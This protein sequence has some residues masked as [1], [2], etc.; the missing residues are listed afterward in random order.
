MDDGRAEA[1]DL[2]S[3]L[4]WVKRHMPLTEEEIRLLPDLH[5]VRLA[6]S[7]HLEPKVAA[8]LEG[9]LDRGAALFLTTCNAA[10]VRDEVVH[11]MEARGAAAHAW[12]GM[13]AAD[14]AEAERRALA[15]K[16]THLWETGANLTAAL[17]ASGGGGAGVAAGM[18][19]T[20]SGITR[21][22]ALSTN[23]TF[24]GFPIYNCDEVPIKE[25][26]HNRYL[27]GQTAWHTFTERTRLSLQRKRV[28]VVGYG[29]VGRGVA[30]VA[31]S[32]GGTVSVAERD[33]TRVLEAR[34]DGFPAG[35]LEELARSADILVT[36]TGAHHVVTSKHFAELADG[37]F[38]MNVGHTDDE[39]DVQALGPRREILP[40]VEEALVGRRTIFLIAGGSMANL[41]AGQGDTL[42]SF[43]I[44][45]AVMLAGVRFTLS[46]EA[47]ALPPGLHPLP[48]SAWEGVARRAASG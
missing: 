47:R 5:G 39:I 10:T 30:E 48:R 44:T 27:V 32:L 7:V 19:S 42:N 18:E 22:R 15:W 36:A 17:A 33:P 13:G 37:C 45:M 46:E 40:F 8:S 12:R 25:R 35:P 43:D 41:V 26:L 28:L 1:P 11:R 38:L 2:D 29:L 20:G 21:L 14:T 24:P 6:C 3:R 4:A 31:R 9:L 23:G 34:Y 16:P